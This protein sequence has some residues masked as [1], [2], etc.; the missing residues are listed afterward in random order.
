MYIVVSYWESLPGREEEFNK[1][2]RKMG[3]LMRRQPGVTL[4]ETFKSGNKYVMVHGYKDEPT[5]RALVQDPKGFFARAAAE[6]KIDEIARWLSSERG[7]P[8]SYE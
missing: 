7:E 8:L 2:G 1:I 4:L 3:A 5:Y 6:H